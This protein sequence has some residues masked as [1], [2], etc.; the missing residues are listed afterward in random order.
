MFNVRSVRGITL[1]VQVYL[2]ICVL[3]C[4]AKLLFFGQYLIAKKSW[5]FNW[6][7]MNG[8]DF[9]LLTYFYQTRT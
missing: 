3:L 5:L 7:E 9:Y 2:D 4:C 6:Y 8:R 1:N